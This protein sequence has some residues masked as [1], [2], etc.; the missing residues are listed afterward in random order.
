MNPNLNMPSN[1]ILKL[2]KLARLARCPSAQKGEATTAAAMFVKIGR[3]NHVDLTG[4]ADLLAL[5]NAT[6]SKPP[7]STTATSKPRNSGTP[8]I[9]PWEPPPVQRPAVAKQWYSKPPDFTSP[10]TR[11]S[12]PKPPRSKPKQSEPE[13]L[14]AV[15]PSGLY[16]GKTIKEIFECDPVYLFWFI[17]AHLTQKNLR[18]SILAF[19]RTEHAANN[20]PERLQSEYQCAVHK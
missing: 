8:F 11:S 7:R 12:S 1:L 3:K 16:R 14:V 18:A 13:T 17:K 9:K 20:I 6:E 15:M 5:A 19:L 2:Q 4:Y 10:Y